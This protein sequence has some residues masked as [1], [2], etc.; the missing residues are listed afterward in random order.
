MGTLLAASFRHKRGAE[1]GNSH[2]IRTL[3]L[4][5][6]RSSDYS[7]GWLKKETIQRPTT[8]M[9]MWCGGGPWLILLPPL[10][11]SNDSRW[12]I[13]WNPIKSSLNG[14]LLTI[15]NFWSQWKCFCGL[16][17]SSRGRGG[18]IMWVEL[19]PNRENQWFYWSDSCSHINSVKLCNF[20]FQWLLINCNRYLC[21]FN[22]F[23]ILPLRLKSKDDLWVPIR[24]AACELNRKPSS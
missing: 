3:P 2:L 10:L 12:T 7:L 23:D 15:S 5:F 24:I 17:R 8:Y 14:S 13:N 6:A 4:S 20:N 21:Y 18:V 11:L 19:I 9:W 22:F 1:D 16:L